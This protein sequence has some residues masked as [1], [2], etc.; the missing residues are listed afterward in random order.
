MSAVLQIKISKPFSIR[1]QRPVR[2]VDGLT[3]EI[4]KRR[5]FRLAGGIRLQANP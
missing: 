5:D 3:L 1:R 4:M 2:A